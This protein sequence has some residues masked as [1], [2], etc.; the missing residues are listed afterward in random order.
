VVLAA[1]VLV[2]LFALSSAGDDKQQGGAATSGT[3][4]QPA[5]AAGEAYGA[6]GG[7]ALAAD[8]PE[9]AGIVDLSEGRAPEGFLEFDADG[10]G[11]LEILVMVRG[12]GKDRLLD[13]Y[14]LDVSGGE[15]RLLFTQK[16]VP[17][18]EL[19]TDGPRL[20]E[21]GGVYAPG[22]DPCCPSS[23]KRTYFVWKDGA[24][25]ESGVEARP[26]GAPSP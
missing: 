24:L 21:T 5:A 22:D 25:S 19:R 20:V 18:G 7:A 13:W 3:T 8:A 11:D 16:D 15:P 14:L 2:L 4:A 1:A 10:D 12:A 26:P 17:Q 9:L 6:G 23:F